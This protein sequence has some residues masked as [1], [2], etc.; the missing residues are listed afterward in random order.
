MDNSLS[1]RSGFLY[2]LVVGTALTLAAG[3][4]ILYLLDMSDVPTL[5]VVGGPAVQQALAWAYRNLGLSLLPFGLILL[6][7]VTSLRRLRHLLESR[8]SAEQIA[9]TDQLLETWTALFFGIGV[10]WTAIGM[11]SALTLAL[12]DPDEAARA[13]AF[14]ILQRLVDGGILVALSTTILGGIGGYL[15]RVIKILLV[16]APL[17][18]RYSAAAHVQGDAIHQTLLSIERSLQASRPGSTRSV[19]SALDGTGRDPG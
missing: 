14:A 8:A 6:L 15:M 13:G 9:H 5:S 17:K 10:L 16:G 12:A 3:V 19:E 7:Y 11:R 4:T 2:G 18:R 1:R